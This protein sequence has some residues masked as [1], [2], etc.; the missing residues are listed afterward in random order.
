MLR[1]AVLALLCLAAAEVALATEEDCV[2]GG[3]NQGD[4]EIDATATFATATYKSENGDVTITG[5]IDANIPGQ[6]LTIAAERIFI[7]GSIGATNPIRLDLTANEIIFIDQASIEA[8]GS[9]PITVTPLEYFLVDTGSITGDVFVGRNI[10]L[11]NV[12]TINGDIDAY[13]CAIGT[14]GPCPAVN[15]VGAAVAINGAIGQIMPL[16]SVFFDGVPTATIAGDVTVIDTLESD[17]NTNLEISLANPDAAW[18][19]RAMIVQNFGVIDL[20]STANFDM[21][22]YVVSDNT[23]PNSAFGPIVI[24]NG[25]AITIDGDNDP[26]TVIQLVNTQAV[27]LS[28]RLPIQVDNDDAA[29]TFD[30]SNAVFEST[31]T[32]TDDSPLAVNGGNYFFKV[33]IVPRPPTIPIQLLNCIMFLSRSEWNRRCKCRS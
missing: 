13:L 2:A 1:I 26:T 5:D 29:V 27:A 16:Q 7:G 8:L 6:V 12:G 18:N 4:C 31:V 20:D 28:C 25:G 19:L 9:A 22:V 15:F 33:C 24:Q 32:A 17:G 3:S 23:A 11:N 30:F 14:D 21:N 10:D